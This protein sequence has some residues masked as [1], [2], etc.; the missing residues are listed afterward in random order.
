VRI[1][2]IGVRFW[3]MI[4]VMVRVRVWIVWYMDAQTAATFGTTDPY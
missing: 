1:G 4:R 3:V 2:A